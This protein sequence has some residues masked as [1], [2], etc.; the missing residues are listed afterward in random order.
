IRSKSS[1]L[2]EVVQ[3]ESEY[4]AREAQ[5]KRKLQEL[6]RS[7]VRL[8]TVIENAAK[9]AGF[10]IGQIRPEEGEPNDEGVVESR[11]D[12][13]ASDLTINRLERFLT[14]VEKTR[15]LVIVRRL[16]ID[17]PYRKDTLN[18]EMTVATYKIE[19]S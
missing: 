19:K 12:L 13:R 9:T 7:N 14:E 4:K 5:R 6:E 8:V 1:Q 11:V 3:L 16:Q 15:G 10:E 18:I 17:K 2:A